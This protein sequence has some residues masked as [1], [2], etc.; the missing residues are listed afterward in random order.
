MNKLQMIL[1]AKSYLEFLAHSI[2]P[3]TEESIKDSV[4]QKPEIQDMIFYT[5]S[6]L[7]ELIANEGE[8]VNVATPTEFSVEKID[9]NAISISDQPIQIGGFVKRINQQ[10]D[11]TKMRSFKPLQLT[12]WLLNNGY[13]IKDKRPVVR[14]VT[15]YSITESSK[16]IGIV[17]QE[18]INSETGEIKK[19]VVLTKTAQEFIVNN[20]D[21]IV[22]LAEDIKSSANSDNHS[23]ENMVGRKWTKDEEKRLIHEFTEEKLTI[24][25]IANLHC[26]KTGGIRARLIRLGLIEKYK[27][28]G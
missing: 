1:K 6:L 28:R 15:V 26:R 10:V 16:E 24:K 7:D 11:N 13:L 18:K 14:N 21:N 5:I 23:T 27:K 25:Q 22:G 9:R 19:S 20:L 17:E 4:L 8:V 12:E 3:T 2:D